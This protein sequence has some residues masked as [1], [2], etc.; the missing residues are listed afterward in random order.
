MS[1]GQ[2]QWGSVCWSGS[3]WS[4]QRIRL[5]GPDA[6]GWGRVPLGS[7]DGAGAL[8]CLPSVVPLPIHCA[9]TSVLWLDVR[10]LPGSSRR[11]SALGCQSGYVRV[12]HVDQKNRGEDRAWGGWG[13]AQGWGQTPE[14]LLSTEILQTWTV[15]QDGPISRVIVF[16]L[17]SPDGELFARGL[18]RDSAGSA[19]PTQRVHTPAPPGEPLQPISPAADGT[20]V[21]SFSSFSALWSSLELLLC[22]HLPLCGLTF[23]PHVTLYSSPPPPPP[24]SSHSV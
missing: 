21:I 1:P 20:L 11:L 24:Q 13:Q 12:A 8:R 9:P 18:E 5:Q 16:S 19:F 2:A 17:S 6:S 4:P 10:N 22:F 14:P 15:L 23:I 7:R 3:D